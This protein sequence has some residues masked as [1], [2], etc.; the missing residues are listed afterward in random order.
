MNFSSSLT[1][2]H[3]F[4]TCHDPR[5][6]EEEKRIN[7]ITKAKNG[8]GGGQLSDERSGYYFHLFRREDNNPQEKT[9]VLSPAA[10]LILLC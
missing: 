9:D 5:L 7:E 6:S 2:L 3:S 4:W 1:T 10:S 8:S